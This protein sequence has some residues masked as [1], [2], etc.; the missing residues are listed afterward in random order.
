MKEFRV[1]EDRKVFLDG[2][3]VKNVL[4]FRVDANAGENPEVALRVPVEKIVI[5]GY[6]DI[7]SGKRDCGYDLP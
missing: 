3:E 4:G 2:Q 6:T 7:C 5:E 1:T